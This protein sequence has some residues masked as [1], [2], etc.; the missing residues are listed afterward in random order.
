MLVAATDGGEGKNS[1]GDR[2]QSPRL[3][4][5]DFIPN[6]TCRK[7]AAISKKSRQTA[8]VRNDTQQHIVSIQ[9]KSMPSINYSAGEGA[10]LHPRAK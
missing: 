2:G 9:L 3:G 10:E 6:R 8:G 5:Q 1:Q 7:G 4:N